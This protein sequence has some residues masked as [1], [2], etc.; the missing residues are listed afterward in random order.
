MAKLTPDGQDVVG[1]RNPSWQDEEQSGEIVLGNPI[2]RNGRE[3]KSVNGERENEGKLLPKVRILTALR[4][5]FKYDTP[6]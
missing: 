6:S 5:P 3:V 2:L 4:F 1:M